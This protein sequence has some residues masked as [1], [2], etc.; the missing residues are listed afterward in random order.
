MTTPDRSTETPDRAQRIRNRLVLI[1]IFALALGP[2]G[3]S[4]LMFG[5]FSSTGPWATTNEGEW[6]EPRLDVVDLD[7]R[8]MRG[9]ALTELETDSRWHL[10]LI[11]DN[12]CVDD[13]GEALH[14]LRQ[15]HVLLNRDA[16]RVRRALIYRDAATRAELEHFGIEYPELI[17]GRTGAPEP[18][19]SL[20]PGAYILDPLGQL[21]LYYRYDQV[22]R[23]LLEDIRHLLKTTQQG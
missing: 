5:H 8:S 16:R 15:L 13:C 14:M 3:V 17:L 21:I 2:L 23:P 20:E 11:A 4:Y 6:V 19:A 18:A 1:G 22:G 12:S 7:L 9:D 10:L